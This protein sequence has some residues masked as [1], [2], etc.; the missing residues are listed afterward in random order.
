MNLEDSIT[1][2]TLNW[3][4]DDKN[5]IIFTENISQTKYLI[6]CWTD[7]IIRIRVWPRGEPMTRLTWAIVDE[8]TG[9][10]PF[11]GRQR[12]EINRNID[13]FQIEE[14][15]H[16]FLLSTKTLT[17]KIYRHKPFAINWIVKNRLLAQDNPICSYQYQSNT[18]YFR[19][20]LCRSADDNDDYYYGLGEKSGPLNKKFRRYRMRNMML[21]ATMLNI[22]IHCINTFLFT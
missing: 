5:N 13:S 10:V 22:A 1:S 11:E 4:R 14:D 3:T 16:Q 20:T 7:D 12:H 2:L 19:H 15:D 18:N 8:Q 6:S 9:D 17:C 21:W